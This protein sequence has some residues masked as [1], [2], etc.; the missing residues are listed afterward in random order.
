M[1]DLSRNFSRGEFECSC[2]GDTK[3]SDELVNVLQELRNELEGP[4][5]ITSAYRC[6]AHNDSVGSTDKSQH[7]LGTAADIVV[8]GCT[9][10]FIYQWLDSKYPNKY[11]MGKY[12]SF[13]HIDVRKRK[14]RW[15]G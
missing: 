7:L 15:N 8:K 5:H 3:I 4:I 12:K 10:A 2:C 1:G 6:K 14:A 11:G 13:V 9:P